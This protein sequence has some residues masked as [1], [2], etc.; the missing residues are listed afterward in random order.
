MPMRGSKQGSRI[1]V[2]HGLALRLHAGPIHRLAGLGPRHADRKADEIHA[3]AGRQLDLAAER[4]GR[5]A[6][7][8]KCL[9]GPIESNRQVPG[10]FCP[11]PESDLVA[12]AGSQCQ[13]GMMVDVKVGPRAGPADSAGSRRGPPISLGPGWHRLGWCPPYSVLPAARK[14]KPAESPPSPTRNPGPESRPGRRSSPALGGRRARFRRASAQSGNASSP[15][16]VRLAAA[17]T[18]IRLP[19]LRS[20][21]T[22]AAT[23][24]RPRTSAPAPA[25]H[26]RR[27]AVRPPTRRRARSR[28]QLPEA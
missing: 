19:G 26:R 3:R 18:Q 22:T 2:Q 16:Q 24:A 23:P 11:A 1:G 21:P 28:C 13:V 10:G 25:G 27:C 8:G 5:P 15:W 7:I 14:S 17:R 20:R 4:T 9:A 12:V 6:Q